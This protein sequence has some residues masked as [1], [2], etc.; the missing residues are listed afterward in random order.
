M[1]DSLFTV[2]VV[3]FNKFVPLRSFFFFDVSRFPK[4]N[5]FFWGGGGSPLVSR[6]S[7]SVQSDS[8]GEDKYEVVMDLLIKTEKLGQKTLPL[9]LCS[10]QI[11]FGL[12]RHRLF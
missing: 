3:D 2:N 1:K 10:P 7:L 9:P 11:L 4:K 6:A 5:N 12:G 8:E